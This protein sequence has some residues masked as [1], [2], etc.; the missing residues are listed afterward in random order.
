MYDLQTAIDNYVSQDCATNPSCSVLSFF[1]PINNWCTS[2]VTDMSFLFEDRA[3]FNANI[4]SWDVSRVTNMKQ[5]FTA[6]SSF[7]QDL[8]GW[9]TSSVTDLSNM[10]MYATSFNQNICQWNTSSVTDMSHMFLL[11]TAFNQDISKWDT[12]SITSMYSMF[13]GAS[14]FNQDI[15]QWNTSNVRDMSGIFFQAT[16]FNRDLSKWDISSISSM[17]F[18]FGGASSFNQDISKWNTSN[19]KEMSGIFHQATVFNQDLSKWDTSSIT[20]MYFMFGNASAFKHD[21]SQWNTSSVVDMSY[22]FHQ[23]TAFNQ[24]L[25]KWDTSRVSQMYEMFYGASSFHQDLSDWKNN[26]PYGAA[27]DIFA[28]S[29]CTYQNTPTSPLDYFCS[30]PTATSSSIH[31]F[32]PDQTKSDV[33]ASC[34]NDGKQPAWMDANPTYW[35][36]STRDKCC[37]QHFSWNYN[38]C[39]GFNGTDSHSWY[40]DWEGD[41]KACLEDGGE[42][43]YMTQNPE[44]YLFNMKQD[45]CKM[46]YSWNYVE[47]LGEDEAGSGEKWYVD[48]ISGDDTCKNDGKAPEYMIQQPSIWLFDKHEDCCEFILCCVCLS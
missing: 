5:M 32:Y 29:G 39:I 20:S 16:A 18:M 45:C 43:S 9:N 17:P 46:H 40:P 36:F 23:A 19:V 22:M 31:L 10:F 15:S 28:Y 38:S 4:S 41:N 3:L 7:N 11:A 2:E 30:R 26:F 34:L 35:L 25:S 12:S 47:C 27:T 42:P 13:H 6:A 21:I 48:W 33:S 37:K 14:S 8:S 44:H 1:G 24:D